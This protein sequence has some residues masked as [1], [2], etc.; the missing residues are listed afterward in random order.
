MAQ[1]GHV[2]HA[3]DADGVRADSYIAKISPTPLMLV[4]AVNDLAWEPGCRR[5]FGDGGEYDIVMDEPDIERLFQVLR[6][7][8]EKA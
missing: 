3:R 5:M 8:R 4:V 6:A 7:D 2:A 1:R